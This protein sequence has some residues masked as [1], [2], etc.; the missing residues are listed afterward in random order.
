MDLKINEG[1]IFRN[2]SDN[3]KAPL[4]TGQINV[5]G[6]NWEIALWPREG[7]DGKKFYS[8]RI[9]EPYKGGKGKP[10]SQGELKPK[11]K[12]KRETEDEDLFG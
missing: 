5:D 7:G 10:K 2:K 6:Q 8:A 1:L 4:F 9:S 3:E 11:P 12:P